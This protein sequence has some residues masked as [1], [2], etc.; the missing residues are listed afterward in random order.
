MTNKT[1]GRLIITK[2]TK[3]VEPDEADR[4]L[5]GLFALLF[6]I[7]RRNLREQNE[8]TTQDTTKASHE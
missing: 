5:L 6:K 3:P 4:N 2:A 7:H 1:K 8:A